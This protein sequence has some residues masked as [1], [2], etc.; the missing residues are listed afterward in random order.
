[1]INVYNLVSLDI[2]KYLHCYHNNPGNKN[3][4]HLLKFPYILLCVFVGGVFFG[5][6]VGNKTT[7]HMTS[8]HLTNV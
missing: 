1:M 6:G 8:T 3:I 7:E 4:H 2:R 5:G